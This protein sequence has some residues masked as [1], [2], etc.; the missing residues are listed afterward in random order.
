MYES[1][2]TAIIPP[3]ANPREFE[4]YGQISGGADE[5]HCQIPNGA[6]WQKHSRMPISASYVSHII[7][8]RTS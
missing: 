4:K 1:I 7:L 8:K 6:G 3:R 2:P 5:T